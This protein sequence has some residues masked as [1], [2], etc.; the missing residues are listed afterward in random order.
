[1]SMLGDKKGMEAVALMVSFWKD[2]NVVKGFYWERQSAAWTHGL[3][4]VSNLHHDPN[5]RLPI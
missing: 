5:Q 2:S 3:A 1:M 4:M